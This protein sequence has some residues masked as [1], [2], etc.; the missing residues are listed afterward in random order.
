MRSGFLVS[1]GKRTISPPACVM[2]ARQAPAFGQHQRAAA[3][4]HDGLGDLERG[5]LRTAGVEPRNDLQ[6]GRP[7]RLPSGSLPKSLRVHRMTTTAPQFLTVGSGVAERRIAYL[8]RARHGRQTARRHVAAG[9]Q[10]GH[11]QHQGVGAGRVGASSGASAA[12][13]STIPAMASRA[14]SSRTARSAA[15]WRRRRPSSSR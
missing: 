4:A 11:G 14:A 6:Y 3:G 12:R 2:R 13:A 1:A 7:L 5:Q 9:L 8:R 15:G 10:V